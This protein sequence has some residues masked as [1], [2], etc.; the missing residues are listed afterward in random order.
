[1]KGRI[2]S[3]FVAA[4]L[5]GCVHTPN[6]GSLSRFAEAT[7]KVHVQA[8][9]VFARANGI[10]RQAAI[11]VFVDSRRPGLSERAFPQ[12]IDADT[13]ASWDAALDDLERYGTLLANLTERA[14]SQ[15]TETGL[16][17]LGQELRNGQAQ[18]RIDPSV[19]AGFAA[20]A[21]V[22]VNA[23]V[24][25]TAKRVM[26]ATDPSV[27][28]LLH[29]MA[30]AIGADR[31]KGL[32]GTVWSSWIA[33]FDDT[34]NAYAVA[35]E[36][37]DETRQRALIADYL[38]AVERRDSDLRALTALRTSLLALADAHTAAA[39]GS[40]ATQAAIIDGIDRRL[41]NVREGF[42]ALGGEMK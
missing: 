27:H 42:R 8:N 20:L 1:L 39:N 32:H 31:S 9:A 15:K 36:K 12:A 11:T 23:S 22:L 34:R 25:S 35:A 13:I 16:I 29:A 24:H 2:L 7:S 21:D 3:L 17:S 38:A 6:Q 5:S 40:A 4:A 26:I 18:L 41:T 30:D 19:G 33:S 14:R 28:R 10:T 37:Q